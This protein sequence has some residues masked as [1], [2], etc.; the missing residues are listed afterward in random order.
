MSLLKRYIPVPFPT[1]Q[2]DYD[3]SIKKYFMDIHDMFIDSG[4]IKSNTINNMDFDNITSVD[5]DRISAGNEI[6][7]SYIEFDYNDTMQSLLGIRIRIE[8]GTYKHSTTPSYGL[9]TFFRV[10]VGI[11]DE[12]SNTMIQSVSFVSN[13]PNNMSTNKIKDYV[14][15][16]DSQ[17]ESFILSN[18]NITAFCFT[19]QYAE[20]ASSSYT[21]KSPRIEFIV[22]RVDDKTIN[23][24]ASTDSSSN[25]GSIYNYVISKVESTS[26][27][28]F[29]MYRSLPS[30]MSEG[31]LVI[32]PVFENDSMLNLTQSDHIVLCKKTAV[33]TGDIIQLK[34][35]NTLTKNFIAMTSDSITVSGDSRLL[36]RVD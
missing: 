12:V 34:I 8:F 27:R 32:F 19:P 28:S 9:Y 10:T 24:Y 15:H 6:S 14:S 26:T 1:Y 3:A 36:V 4:F 22:N 25:G 5:I 30:C 20:D 29:Y 23:V 35:N 21:Y 13:V 33:N 31:K 11:I 17:L 18:G 2:L 7:P 16:Y